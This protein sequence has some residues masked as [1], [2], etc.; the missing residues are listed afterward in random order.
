M[1]YLLKTVLGCGVCIEQLLQP[2]LPLPR[3]VFIRNGSSPQ[4]EAYSAYK[5]RVAQLYGADH[6]NTEHFVSSTLE[7]ERKLAEVSKKYC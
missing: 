3:E 2:D 6:N 7:F 1:L 5:R 4:L